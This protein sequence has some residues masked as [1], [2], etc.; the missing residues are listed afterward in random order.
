[1]LLCNRRRPNA[2]GGRGIILPG[3]AHDPARTGAGL[4]ATSYWVRHVPAFCIRVGA[5]SDALDALLA[6]HGADTWAFITAHNPHSQR[7]SAQENARRERALRAELARQGL[8]SVHCDGVADDGTW[9][10]EQGQLIFGIAPTAAVALGRAFG[11]N[12]ILVGRHG[13]LPRL[14]FCAK[15]DG[16]E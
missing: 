12:A 8:A 14:L 2:G 9:P 11:Q 7:Q 13:E 16:R 5:A 15:E 6:A 1:M 4:S 3:Y 10:T